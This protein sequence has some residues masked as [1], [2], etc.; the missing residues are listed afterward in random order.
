MVAVPAKRTIG[1][2][3]VA[4]LLETKPH[5]DELRPLREAFAKVDGY[6]PVFKY[7][8]QFHGKL[9]SRTCKDRCDFLTK[10][11]GPD[12]KN[13]RVLDVGCS[14]GYISLS[15]AELGA[16]VKGIDFLQAN[17]DFCKLLSQKTGVKVSF[18]LAE[19]SEPLCNGIVEGRYDVVLLFSV[20][21]HVTQRYGVPA[22]Q[23][24]MRQLLEKCDVLYVE[25]AR[26]SEE[27]TFPWRKALPENEL[28]IFAGIPDVEIVEVA[29]FPALGDTVIRPMYRV[30]KSAKVFSNL[31]HKPLVIKRSQIKSGA[32]RDRK[33]AL[34]D[35]L[36]TK[37]FI[38]DKRDLY[39]R[40]AAELDVSRRIGPHPNFLPVIGSE[41]RGDLAAI[42]WPLVHGKSL[43]QALADK[44]AM[45]VREVAL[46][47]V[48]I[49][50]RKPAFFGTICGPTTLCLPTAGSSLSTSRWPRHVR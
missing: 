11:L 20:L 23:R 42:T 31:T 27:V 6:Q 33:Y 35:T 46:A 2:R 4:S 37:L 36:F 29:K 18:D 26:K 8:E 9:V 10:E 48:E 39:L 3:T 15:L 13:L 43:M 41:L 38:V 17:V 49:P 19:F 24:M 7:E 45:D 5:T 40:F 12:I 16:S 47:V 25:L 44:D 28:E 32:T 22:V 14:M 21:H 34:S 50:C 30:R 1:E